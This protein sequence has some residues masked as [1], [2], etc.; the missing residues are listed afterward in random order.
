MAPFVSYTPSVNTMANID[1]WAERVSHNVSM[2]TLNMGS[3]EQREHVSRLF[4]NAHEV[5]AETGKTYIDLRFAELVEHYNQDMTL[6]FAN[7]D[8]IE[9]RNLSSQAQIDTLKDLVLVMKQTIDKQDDLLAAYK[10]QLD[11]IPAGSGAAGRVLRPRAGTSDGL[12]REDGLSSGGGV[13]PRGPP[14]SRCRAP[15]RSE[16]FGPC[17][18]GAPGPF[19]RE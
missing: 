5:T 6:A 19:G 8:A 14:L 4:A 3:N 2:T 13:P 12:V 18:A 15:C 10:K 9:N 11:A 16:G 7:N 17:G 1:H